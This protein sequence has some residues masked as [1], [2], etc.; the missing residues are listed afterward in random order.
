MMEKPADTK[1][2]SFTEM[3]EAMPPTAGPRMKPREK[4]TLKSPMAFP[5]RFSV[6][7]S[8]KSERQHGNTAPAA[9]PSIDRATKARSRESEKA[10]RREAAKNPDRPRKRTFFR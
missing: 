1:K 7:K 6:V 8:D 5:R 2:T 10:K 4:V 9:I 3:A